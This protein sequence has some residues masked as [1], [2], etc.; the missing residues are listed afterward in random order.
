MAIL[1]RLPTL[2]TIKM[3]EAHV[4]SHSGEFCLTALWKDL[5]RQVMYPTYKK[6]IEYLVES[7]KI[8]IDSEGKVVWIFNPKV[9]ERI[10]DWPDI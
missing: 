2:T 10:K 7:C 8:A 6:A 9:L 1:E 3:I 5:P 4:E